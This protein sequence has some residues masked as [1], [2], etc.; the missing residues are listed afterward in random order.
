MNFPQPKSQAYTGDTSIHRRSDHIFPSNLAAAVPPTP[1]DTEVQAELDRVNQLLASLQM[2]VKKSMETMFSSTDLLGRFHELTFRV[3]ELGSPLAHSSQRD[4][5]ADGWQKNL[6]TAGEGK[7]KRDGE[8]AQEPLPADGH[9]KSDHLVKY[10]INR[11]V[12]DPF[13][14]GDINQ[15]CRS[16]GRDEVATPPTGEGEAGTSAA[17]DEAGRKVEVKPAGAVWPTDEDLEK[18]YQ[19]LRSE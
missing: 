7:G 18:L 6:A 2:K 13:V 1:N 8:H 15:G 16:K 17:A 9:T 11:P 4:S 12:R 10:Q 14:A 5:A 3:D 19:V